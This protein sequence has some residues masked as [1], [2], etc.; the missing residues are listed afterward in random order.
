MAPASV[1]QVITA[2]SFHHNVVSPATSGMRILERIKVSATDTIDVSQTSDVEIGIA[3]S[4]SLFFQLEPI[5]GRLQLRNLPS[6][7]NLYVRGN[8]VRNPYDQEVDPG[9]YE[10]YAEA[11]EHRPRR[12]VVQIGPGE[13]LSLDFRLQY[14]QRSGR[15]ELI[16]FWT[17][18]GVVAGATAVAASLDRTSQD[19]AKAASSLVTAGGLV[20]GAVGVVLATAYVPDYIRDNLAL[21]RIGAMSVGAIEGAAIG[22]AGFPRTTFTAG[23]TGGV[24][25]LGAGAVAGIALDGYA[26]NY[27]RVTVIESGAGLGALAG[28]LTATAVKTDNSR[29]NQPLFVLGGLNLGLGAGLALAYLPDQR[30]RGPTWRRVVLIDLAAA[31]GAFAGAVTTQ[32]TCLT[33]P[34]GSSD[35]CS[36]TSDKGQTARFALVGGVVGLAAGWFLTRNL[37][38]PGEPPV[39]RG[40]SLLPLPSAISVQGRD[41]PTVIPGLAAQGRF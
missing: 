36:L 22:A 27:G 13:H 16:A 15:P 24:L 31:A 9:S 7:A 2:D 23:L 32:V 30:A 1:P 14:V 5:P 39:D 41:G 6:T 25:G 21:F 4:K 29:R 35:T 18:A 37:D 40:A 33:K 19:N 3:E 17:A 26:P 10:I 12:E 20:G 28:A 34:G 11:S 38:H 8:R